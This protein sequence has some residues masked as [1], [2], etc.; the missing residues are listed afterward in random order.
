MTVAAAALLLLITG[1][2]S[3]RSPTPEGPKP[4]SPKEGLR[5]F[6]LLVGSWK[7]TG[8]PEGTREERAAGLWTETITWSW[9]FKG[10]DAW[11]AATFDKG[12]YY[13]K[14]EL[15]Y[16]VEKQT[17][18]LTL[19]APDK[20]ALTFVGTLKDKVLTLD[21]TGGPAGEDQRLVLTLL[22]HNRYLY[23]FD[24]RAAGSALGFVKQFQVGA[25]KEG[26]PFAEVA[27]G[28]ECIV[29]GGLGTMKVTHNGKEYYVCCTGCRDAFKENPEKYIKEAEQK[30][31]E[32]K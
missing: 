2:E 19:T 18:Q 29:S 22:H 21:R 11:L 32:K 17:Y 4:T 7:G 10:D 26:V 5:P 12:K 13:A 23:R 24:T 16:S 28:P 8:Y 9:Q 3:P 1:A 30:A 14:A 6:N 25:T 27:K 31:K 15:R 20:S